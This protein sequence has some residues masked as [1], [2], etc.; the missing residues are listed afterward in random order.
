MLTPCQVNSVDKVKSN[1][2]S[3]IEIIKCLFI[4]HI[5]TH[6]H[7]RLAQNNHRETREG[8]HT[9]RNPQGPQNAAQITILDTP[10]HSIHTVTL[11]SNILSSYHWSKKAE[12]KMLT[13]KEI[14]Q[15][16]ALGPRVSHVNAKV[17][18]GGAVPLYR[19]S[20][21]V[22]SLV[23]ICKRQHLSHGFVVNLMKRKLTPC[24]NISNFGLKRQ[25]H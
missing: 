16:T 24:R 15:N 6:T 11:V 21:V 2:Y 5:Q 20:L 17:G 13:Q 18:R 3:A 14:G 10:I 8:S 23:T 9:L 22:V 4:N 12:S 7:P 1:I 25:Y 19:R